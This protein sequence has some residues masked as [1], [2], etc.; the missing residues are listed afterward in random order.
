MVEPAQTLTDPFTAA[1]TVLNVALCENNI[2]GT[3]IPKNKF[4]Q[5]RKPIANFSRRYYYSV[6]Y[7]SYKD[8]KIEIKKEK[9][10][11]IKGFS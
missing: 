8:D 6:S 11:E 2:P 4:S 3:T 1:G 10:K 5:K 9:I 7:E